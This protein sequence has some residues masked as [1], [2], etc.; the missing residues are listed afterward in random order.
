MAGDF[1]VNCIVKRGDHL[2]PHERIEAL[3]NSNANWILSEG[4]VIRRIE[5]RQESYYTLVN[6]RRADIVV[7][8]HN[9]RKYLKTSADGY[10]LNNS[11]N[12]NDCPNC[13]LLA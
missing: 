6:G 2:D 1:Q 12:L 7:A 11:L 3:G 8:A 4:E 10:A 5:M 9:G 13:K